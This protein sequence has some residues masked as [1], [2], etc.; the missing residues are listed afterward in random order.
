MGGNDSSHGRQIMRQ[1][2]TAGNTQVEELS[3]GCG[4]FHRG[5]NGGSLKFRT[6]CALV[7]NLDWQTVM[8]T[9]TATFLHMQL[10]YCQLLDVTNDQLPVNHGGYSNNK[11]C[12]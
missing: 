7:S 4:W 3:H 9:H 5:D 11:L 2:I 10:F 12:T 1:I 8:H 6:R